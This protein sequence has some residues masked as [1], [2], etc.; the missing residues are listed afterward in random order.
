MPKS[1]SSRHTS[2]PGAIM[3]RLVIGSCLAIVCGVP[4]YLAL[5]PAPETV[6]ARC[7]RRCDYRQQV[8]PDNGPLSCA[9][10]CA[11]LP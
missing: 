7:L 11:G 6:T 5:A 1:S 8:K 3:R 10:R 4:L 9:E 2:A